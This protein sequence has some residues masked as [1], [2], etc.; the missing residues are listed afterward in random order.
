MVPDG[1]AVVGSL[2]TALFGGGVFGDG[3]SGSDVLVDIV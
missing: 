3:V 1:V 2:V